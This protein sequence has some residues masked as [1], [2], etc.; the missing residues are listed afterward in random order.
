[1]TRARVVFLIDALRPY[2]AERVALDLAAA[3]QQTVDITM[4]TYKGDPQIN[5]SHVPDGVAHIHLGSRSRRFRRLVVTAHSFWRLLRQ[6]RPTAIISFMPYANTV[7]AACGALVHVPV[8]ATEHTV[9]SIAEYGGRE[10]PLLHLA[11]RWYLRRVPAIVGVSQT[12]SRDLV[13]AFG[14][15]PERV[16]TIY[17]PLDK[18]RILES[19]RRGAGA[20]PSPLTTDEVRVVVVG[21]LKEAKGHEY[22]LSALAGLPPWFRLYVVGDG[23][24]LDTLQKQAHALGIVD[25]VV[26][27]GWQAD[28][29]AWLQAA[30]IVWVPSLW[31]GFGLVLAEACALGRKVIPSAAPGLAEVA[32]NLG[33]A[34]VPPRDSK[35]LAEA[36]LRLHATTTTPPVPRW[37]D[38]LEPAAVAARYLAVVSRCT[39]VE[40][41]R[42][43]YPNSPHG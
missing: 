39:G 37:L 35:A 20:I 22:A 33:C 11:M 17:N 29:P 27:V 24:L 13:D 8:I 1:L 42:A 14:A 25:R 28:A 18:A 41:R 7:A 26:F 4:V 21:R 6:T 12:V 5:A 34:T 2:G 40:L 36:T 23:P 38:E 19:A 10:R 43:E 15:R 30:D 3:M 32:D 31:D 9:M 16:S